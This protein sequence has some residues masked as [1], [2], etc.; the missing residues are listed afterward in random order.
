MN[1]N[2]ILSIIVGLVFLVSSSTVQASYAHSPAKATV[3]SLIRRAPRDPPET[4]TTTAAGTRP[5]AR[6]AAAGENGEVEA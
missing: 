3:A 6:R 1:H 5:S 4:A 2:R